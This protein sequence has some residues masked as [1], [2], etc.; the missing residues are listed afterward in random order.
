[1]QRACV[2]SLAGELRVHKMCG[3]AKINKYINKSHLPKKNK[4]DKV[5]KHLLYADL[6]LE[7]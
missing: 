4:V 2:R 1:M 7:I 5:L 6:R 3:M